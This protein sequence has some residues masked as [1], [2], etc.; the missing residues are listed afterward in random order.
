M[1][2]RSG[3]DPDRIVYVGFDNLVFTRITSTTESNTE[4]SR[5]TTTPEEPTQPTGNYILCLFAK[6]KVKLCFEIENILK[7]L[8]TTS[9]SAITETGATTFTTETTISSPIF[10]SSTSQ[11]TGLPANSVY[12]CN[13]DEPNLCGGTTFANNSGFSNSFGSQQSQ[14][15]V[16][17]TVTDITSISNYILN[18]LL[19]VSLFLLVLKI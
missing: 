14:I 9:I 6:F 19:R 12:F 8:Q 10:I 1:I 13:L 3:S 16:S 15:I 4:S 11:F 7:G 5:T 17:T 18:D 2:S